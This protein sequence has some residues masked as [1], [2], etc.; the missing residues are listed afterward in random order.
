MY[1]LFSSA[2]SCP[3]QA[4]ENSYVQIAS[5]ILGKMDFTNKISVLQPHGWCIMYDCKARNQRA[6]ATDIVAVAESSDER[7]AFY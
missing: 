2:K 4:R 7:M 1:L 3:L 5:W 6:T